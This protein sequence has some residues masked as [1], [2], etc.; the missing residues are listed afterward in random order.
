MTIIHDKDKYLKYYL[1]SI[2][3][4]GELRLGAIKTMAQHKGQGDEYIQCSFDATDEDYKEGYV[5]L[6]FWKPA[7]EEDV[8]V[9]VENRTFYESLVSICNETIE[10]TPKH[11][12]ELEKNL[13]KIKQHLSL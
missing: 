2:F 8:I 9:W 10:R 4:L 1:Q 7:V 12:K 11:K 5:T 13:Q 6:Y 3:F